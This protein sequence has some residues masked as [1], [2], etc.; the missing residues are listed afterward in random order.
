MTPSPELSNREREVI[1]QLLAGKSNKEIAASLNISIRTVEFHL[2][3]I[4]DKLGVSTRVELI[5]KLGDST[6]VPQGRPAVH[7]P[8]PGLRNWANRVKD[9]VIGISKE[10]LSMA[11]LPNA[12][13]SGGGNVMTFF[14]AIRVCLTRYADFAGRAGRPEFWWFALFV[15]L[16]VS[17]VAYVSEALGGLVLTVLLLPFLAVGARRLRDSG[18]SPWWLLMLL[19][20]VGGLV[21]LGFLWARPATSP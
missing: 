16:A 5:L 6:V 17:A 14:E 13:V 3:N 2:G 21:A 15:T 8:R 4:Y 1:H 11:S 18:Q 12:S 9:A 19:V 10:E 20:P 7:N